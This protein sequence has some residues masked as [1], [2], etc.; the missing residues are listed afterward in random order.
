MHKR[1]HVAEEKAVF[2]I[3]LE[4]EFYQAKR[5]FVHFGKIDSG[6]ENPSI[7]IRV[8]RFVTARVHA[9]PLRAKSYEVLGRN[10]R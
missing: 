10:R 8:D 7:E 2:D 4:A 5:T 3:D 1:D 9:D 6:F